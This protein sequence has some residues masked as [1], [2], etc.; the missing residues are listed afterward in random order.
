MSNKIAD[1]T[2]DTPTNISYTEAF[3]CLSHA[4]S[5]AHRT[6]LLLQRETHMMKHYKARAL[7]IQQLDNY[8]HHWTTLYHTLQL[9][10]RKVYKPLSKKNLTYRQQRRLYRVCRRCID[11]IEEAFTPFQPPHFP[12]PG[13]FRLTSKHQI[14]ADVEETLSYLW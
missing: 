2:G 1:L 8:E 4:A 13:H 7:H 12:F 5:I 11:N 14:L 9:W 3:C 6:I 10:V